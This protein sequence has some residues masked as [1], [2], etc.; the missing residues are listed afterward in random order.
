MTTLHFPK[1][2]FFTPP[3][4]VVSLS[5]YKMLKMC[6]LIWTIVLWWVLTASTRTY[7]MHVLQSWCTLSTKF[8]ICHYQKVHCLPFSMR[9][10]HHRNMACLAFHCLLSGADCF[11]FWLLFTN[12]VCLSGIALIAV[13]FLLSCFY[14]WFSSAMSFRRFSSLVFPA[15][16]FISFSLMTP[17]WAS[18]TDVIMSVINWQSLSKLSAPCGRAA[19]A[20]LSP[21]HHYHHEYGMKCS[22]SYLAE[23]VFMFS[24]LLYIVLVILLYCTSYNVQC[25]L[26]C[27][28]CIYSSSHVQFLKCIG[29][30]KACI[31]WFYISLTRLLVGGFISPPPL[32]GFFVYHCQTDGDKELKLSDF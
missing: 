14:H 8:S 27:S 17:W 18:S 29:Y 24:L 23:N 31:F 11:R 20:P 28:I 6:S 2:V 3:Y 7:W 21:N 5:A 30:S 13:L 9:T 26:A 19:C 16:K 22:I 32:P 25:I 12:Y 4:W 1:K 10:R 15:F